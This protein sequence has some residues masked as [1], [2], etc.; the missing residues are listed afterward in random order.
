MTNRAEESYR[1]LQELQV[2]LSDSPVDLD[3]VG[4]YLG[5]ALYNLNLWD[6]AELAYSGV[7]KQSKALVPLHQA[8]LMLGLGQA[9]AAQGR[10][11]DA[12]AQLI[13]AANQYAR[14]NNP[15]WQ[16]VTI[17]QLARIDAATGRE[18]LAIQ[19]LLDAE[20]L[21]ADAPYYQAQV[22]IDLSR[23][24]EDRLTKA[25]RL[26]NR[27]GYAGLVWQIHYLKAIQTSSP[28]PHYRRMFAA[29]VAG[30]LATNSVAAR[31]GFFKDKTEA[32]QAYLGWLLSFPSPTRVAE[33]RRAIEQAR[34]AT[35]IDEILQTG[36]L[37]PEIVSRLRRVRDELQ[38]GDGEAPKGGS[39]RTEARNSSMAAVQKAATEGLLSLDLALQPYAATKSSPLIV[40][41]T[42][43]GTAVL[44][45]RRSYNLG[46][47][48]TDLNEAL[49]WLPY[50]L[51]A[52]MAD[53]Q[54]A[55]GPA[56]D[57]IRTLAEI[58]DPVW[59]SSAD[60]VCPDGATWRVPWSI[61]SQLAGVDREWMI[62]IHPFMDA[63]YEGPLTPKSKCAVWLGSSPDLRFAEREAEAI[64]SHFHSC[65]VL[66]SAEEVRTSLQQ[67][68]E[69][70][71]IV[72]HATHRPLNPM[73]SSLEFPD[74]PVYA[75]EI[76]RSNLGVNLATL[77]ACETGAISVATRSEPDG[78]ARAF[79]ARGAQSVIASQWPLDDEAAFV[80]FNSL[81][82]SLVAGRSVREALSVAKDTAKQWRE[83]P[84]FWGPLGL[85]A[86]YRHEKA[87]P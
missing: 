10:F 68:Y 34:S 4:E 45:E 41:E 43:G 69:V 71:H 15:T 25:E 16:G 13:K 76:A 62:A 24:G 84:Y 36:S 37:P 75:Y 1:L 2:E 27:Y 49:R 12:K 81:Y 72:S 30:R 52:P 21:T 80:Q 53:P 59:Q 51:L 39:R 86:G 87:S 67:K 26:V 40:V 29:I 57:Q 79:I 66:R 48:P 28:G 23:L 22:L 50:E 32:V 60:R 73:L 11:A 85:Y 31:L 35:L 38:G 46:G 47:S 20:K 54:A 70:V 64:I 56:L 5:D 6:E 65:Q 14:L 63:A 83:H 74:G 42:T 19:K 61:C 33:A 18:A 7:L 3:R 58:L 77:S 9:L 78:L 17:T 8:N 55:P 44:S 82:E